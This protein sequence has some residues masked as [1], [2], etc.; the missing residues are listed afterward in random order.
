[1]KQGGEVIYAGSSGHHSQNVIKY[2]EALLL[3][4][5][6]YYYLADHD[7]AMR[8][9]QK[10]LRLDLEHSE[11]KKECFKL[12]NILKKSKSIWK[13]ICQYGFEITT[14]GFAM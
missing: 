11:L 8:H 5:K 13:W 14:D 1:M 7:V 6:G 3:C 10:G 4:G 2:F 9:Y 12:K